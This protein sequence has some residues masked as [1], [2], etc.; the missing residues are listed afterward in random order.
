M[1][2]FNGYLTGASEKYFFKKSFRYEQN[3]IIFG[4]IMALPM[5]IMLTMYFMELSIIFGYCLVFAFCMIMVRIKTPKGRKAITP[6]RIY[7]EDDTIVCIADKY[8]ESKLVETVKSVKDYG[9]FYDI[10]FPF[11]NLS[12]K[13]ICQKSLLTK[14]TPEQFE[15]MFDG[16]IV[17]MNKNS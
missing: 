11:G 10:S 4:L 16:K 12:S 2:E 13:Y 8:S 3:I 1:L 14:G 7:I 6:K 5:V 17:R 15:K 9:E